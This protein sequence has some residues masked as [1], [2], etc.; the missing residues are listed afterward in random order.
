LVGLLNNAIELNNFINH[1]NLS[2]PHEPIYYSYW[3]NDW[4]TIL[5]L[6][7][8]L[9]LNI[10]INTRV[11][12]YDFE[13]EF[14][15]RRYLPFRYIE[16]NNIDNVYPISDYAVKYIYNRFN[17]KSFFFR[18]GVRDLGFNKI[19]TKTNVFKVVTCSSLSWYKRPL[20]LADL[21]C[22][23]GIQINWVHFGDG[24]MEDKFLEK[25]KLLPNNINFTYK[26]RVSNS[27]ILEYYKT[28]PV[29]L[30]L[31]VSSF[32]GIPVS[33][34]EAISFG[35]PIV[36]CNMC[37]MPEIVTKQTGILLEVDFNPKQAARIL[38]YFLESNARNSSFR[39]GVKDFWKENFD[40]DKNYK[41]FVIELG[42]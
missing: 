41:D 34:M 42:M 15:S 38:E 14:N 20:L 39:K 11:H 37:G 9:G 19:E 10:E 13:E 32:E 12:L 28:N 22:K 23:F 30:V 35:I 6:I 21:F 7:K 2:K 4:A 5:L 40:A 29:D 18:L 1:L 36:G 16:L 31:N 24:L 3:F 8:E 25:T 26:G 33:L 17:E 27:E